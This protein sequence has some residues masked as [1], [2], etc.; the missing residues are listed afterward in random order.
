MKAIS[1]VLFYRQSAG[2]RLL[3]SLKYGSVRAKL[4]QWLEPSVRYSVERLERLWSN[5]TH[6]IVQNA[7]GQLTNEIK[8]EPVSGHRD[9]TKRAGVATD[10][11]RLTWH[12]ISRA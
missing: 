2:S 9:G 3:F 12:G 1:C 11:P 4:Q 8:R 5:L 6:P 7:K 10:R